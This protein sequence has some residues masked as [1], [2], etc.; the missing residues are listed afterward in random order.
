MLIDLSHTVEHGMITYKGLPAPI[1]CDYLSR[2]A[3]RSCTPR[4]PSSTSARSRWWPTPGRTSTR[5][6]HRYADG[7]DLSELP[8]ERLADLE[9]SSS[10]GTAGGPGRRAC[11][12]R[13]ARPS[14]QGGA[15]PDGLGRPLADG[16]LLRGA[17]VPDRRRRRVLCGSGRGAGRH[18]L[19]TTST[20]RPTWP[21][22]CIPLCCGAEIPIVEHLTRAGAAARARAAA[23]SPCR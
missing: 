13:R 11:G 12:L 4:A 14:R 7:K 9:A 5:P 16:P 19:A 2:E 21:A 17:P 3:S 8:L 15:G 1:V 18:R 20:T 10:A 6:F 23:S 22:P